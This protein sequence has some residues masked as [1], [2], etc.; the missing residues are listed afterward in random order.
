M[1]YQYIN[2]ELSWLEF[3]QRVLDQAAQTTLPLLERIKF[4]AITASNLDEF[5]MVRVGGLQMLKSSGSLSK[6]ISGMTPARQLSAIRKR[7]RKMIDDQYHLLDD[8]IL[9]LM[10]IEKISPLTPAELTV[11]QHMFV[12]QYFLTQVSPLLTLLDMEVDV[13]PALPSLRLLFGLEVKD[14]ATKK[15]RFCVVVMPEGVSRFIYVPDVDEHL[16][17]ML[18]EDVVKMFVNSVFPGETVTC[19]TVFRVTRNG[20]IAAEEDAFD[21][22]DEMEE[23]LVA[24][25]YSECVRLEIEAATPRRLAGNIKNITGV[26][27]SDIYELSGPLMLSD[28]FKMA[29]APGNDHL[30]VEQ[31]LPQAPPAIDPGISIFDNIAQGDLLLHHPYES[32]EPVLR[33]M[34]EAAIDPEVVAIK[35]VLYRTSRDSRIIDAL[36]KAAENGKQVTVLIEL[37]ARFDEASNLEKAELLQRAGVQVVYGVKGLKTHAK[38]CLVM[39]KEGGVLKRYCH[40]GTG[41]YNETTARIYTDIS[42]LTSDEHLG[43]DASQFFNTVTGR[44]KLMRFRKLYPSPDLM[45]ERLLELIAGETERARQGDVAVI[46]AKMNSL[47]DQEIINALYVAADAGVDIK[48]NIRGICCLKTE[49]SERIKVVS[50]VDR[51]LEHARIFYFKHGDT[52]QY[53]IASADWMSRNLDKR[54]ELMVPVADARHKRRLK[55]I[56]DACFKDNVQSYRILPDGTSERIRKGNQKPFRIQLSLTREAKKHAKNKERHLQQ[57]MEPH[58]PQD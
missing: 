54:V 42:Y 2:R 33:L 7:V 36:K 41:N 46:M 35:Q 20:D 57:M 47:Q 5:F 43:A 27:T 39:R 18:L 30:K 21:L 52:P 24:R 25:K 50:I 19:A 31:W 4:L 6:D 38:I 49:V 48:L 12:E 32:F 29:F 23:V 44:T 11:P 13:P 22:A 3:N 45:K 10:E 9:P 55:S 58:L 37:K 15:K 51:Y 53:F 40:F 34:E 26:S 8:E 17:Y 1:K 16:S 28:F 14:D 56:L